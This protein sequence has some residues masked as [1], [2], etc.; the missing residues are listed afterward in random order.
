MNLVCGQER[1]DVVGQ[2]IPTPSALGL[3]TY[4][5]I[6]KTP[7]PPA[8]QNKSILGDYVFASQGGASYTYALT[9]P[10]STVAP[11]FGL[12]QTVTTGNM[13]TTVAAGAQFNTVALSLTEVVNGPRTRTVV[14]AENVAIAGIQKVTA[15]QIY[16]N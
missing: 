11:G 5:T 13:Q 10:A 7:T 15:A 6:V 2:Y 14:G 4:T 3:G 12:S 8:P 1:V 16:L 9:N